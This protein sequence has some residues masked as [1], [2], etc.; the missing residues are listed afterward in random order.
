L[1]VGLPQIDLYTMNIDEQTQIS[2][3]NKN[4]HFKPSSFNN[5]KW[6]RQVNTLKKFN[7]K[8]LKHEQK[9][10]LKASWEGTDRFAVLPTGF[11]KSLHYQMVSTKRKLSSE[12]I[13]K[14]KWWCIRDFFRFIC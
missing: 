10:I 9:D 7:L 2:L 4:L 11:G 12:T 13:S 14:K 3:S 6:Q 5:T 1:R 8:E